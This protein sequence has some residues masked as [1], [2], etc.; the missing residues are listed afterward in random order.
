MPLTRATVTIA[1]SVML[2]VYPAF[3]FGIGLSFTLTP[4]SR[5]VESPSLAYADDLFAL[6]LWGI[7]YLAVAAALGIALVL[8]RRRLYQ[9]ALLVMTL[10][11]LLWAAVMAYAAAQ[12]QGSYSAWT[13]P[14]FIAAACW[15]TLL[16]LE[17]GES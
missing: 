15:A 11:M 17:A 7:G 9:A 4:R 10:W 8:H 14:A 1:S 12:G 6:D 13:W 2:K 16:S 5:L 3:A